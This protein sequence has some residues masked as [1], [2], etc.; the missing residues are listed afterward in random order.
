MNLDYI[1]DRLWAD[2]IDQNPSAGKIYKLFSDEKE[3]VVNDHIAF[4]T[5]DYPLINTDVLAAK[6]IKNGYVQKGECEF[7]DTHL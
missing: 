4:R 2:Y 7:K 1:F 3:T 5:L 6:F